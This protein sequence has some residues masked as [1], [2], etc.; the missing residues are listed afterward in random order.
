[1]PIEVACVREGYLK[2][3]MTF[4]PATA[5][6]VEREAG[7]K[8]WRQSRS[9]GDAIGY[10]VGELASQGA[11]LAFPPAIFGIIAAGAAS[12]A[13]AEAEKRPSLSYAYRALPEFILIP[14]TF[15]SEST[16]DAFFVT[17]KGK[18]EANANAQ[19]DYIN[20]HCRFWPCTPSDV[21]CPDPVCNRARA[22]IEEQLKTQLDRIPV[23]L[24]QTK[25]VAPSQ[26]STTIKATAV[27][28]KPGQ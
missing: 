2:A 25:I 12:T 15:S 11:V 13:H 8:P 5:D 19:L 14:A 10:F 18:L 20:E 3:Q 22:V 24:T 16:R 26:A 21:V 7:T 27:S 28:S 17:L 4:A 1:V 23:L 6:E 9:A